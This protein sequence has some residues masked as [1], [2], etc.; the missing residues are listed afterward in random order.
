MTDDVCSAQDFIAD[1]VPS[2]R[3]LT[4]V[5]RGRPR[6]HL[7]PEVA[8]AILDAIEGGMSVRQVAKLPNMPSRATIR[9]LIRED[10]EFCRQYLAAKDGYVEDLLEEI[11]EI[12]HDESCDLEMSTG[13]D[14]VPAVKV[15]NKAINRAK[16]QIDTHFR[17]IATHSPKKYGETKEAP[18]VA[19]LEPPRNGDNAKVIDVIPIDEH[20]LYES[21]RA[22][23][24]V[25]DVE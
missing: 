7:Q 12:A 17:L 21:I 15:N 25:E 6:V 10:P 23:G 2:N 14:G 5:P 11:Y 4:V 22:W 18:V 8:E 19:Q 20:P 1:E 3:A 24:I 13:D 16:L 9:R